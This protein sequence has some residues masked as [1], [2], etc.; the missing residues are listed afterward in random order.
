M[1]KTLYRSGIVFLAVLALA[2]CAAFNPIEKPKV[3]ITNI[4]MA[5]VIGFQQK[6]LVG[7]QLDNPNGFTINLARLRYTLE[8]QGQS[9]AG[10]SLNEAISLPANGQ[11][12]LVV[13][14]EVNL[15]SGIGVLSKILGGM[16]SDL[17]YKLSLTA[18]VSN[19]GLGDITI[20][21][22]GKV[23]IGTTAP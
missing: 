3:S 16:Q 6:L 18:A 8:L 19:F 1:I 10:G 9:L 21:K 11:T 15:L 5:P 13:P 12:Q 17:D 7:L 22:V 14:V 2:A 20:D 23:G 4:Q